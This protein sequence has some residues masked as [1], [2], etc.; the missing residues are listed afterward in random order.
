MCGFKRRFAKTLI[1]GI[2]KV[3]GVKEYSPR[4]VDQLRRENSSLKGIR[5]VLLR[6]GRRFLPEELLLGVVFFI[7]I[8]LI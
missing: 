6:L 1:E 7:F 8:S 4:V 3:G 5:K 2:S